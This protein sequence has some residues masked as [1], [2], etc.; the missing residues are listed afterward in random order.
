MKHQKGFLS[1]HDAVCLLEIIHKSLF[2]TTEGQLT[3]LI[4]EL[5]DIVPFDYAVSAL[6]ELD[7]Y[8]RVKAYK[9]VNTSYPE[10][11]L[12]I[13]RDS[14]YHAVDP[15]IKYNFSSFNLQYWKD[16]YEK[17]SVPKKFLSTADSFGLTEGYSHGVRNLKGDL[18]SVFSFG[19]AS[20]E[21]HPRS[22]AILN[23]IVPHLHQA[24]VRTIGRPKSKQTN[25]LSSREKEALTW[26]KR[27]KSTWDI[28]SILGISEN[29][30]KFHVKTIL[31]KLD[32][33]S[34]TQAVA[35]ALEQRLIDID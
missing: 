15:V 31:Q 18:G 24:I 2:C 22:E 17:Y 5:K 29:T 6:A 13:Y 32:A 27:G 33:V 34:R 21:R 8:A 10:E 4:N 14:G 35:I 30:V 23:Y 16:T 7:S 12:S 3:E 26:I 25:C 28:S 1:G 11:W 19:G 20:V 9:T